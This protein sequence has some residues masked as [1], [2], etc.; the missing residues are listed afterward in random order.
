M[1]TKSL[2]RLL[3][4]AGAIA[5]VAAVSVS[6]YLNPPSAV[7]AHALDQ[8]R[9]Q[10]L[11]QIDSAIKAYYRRHQVLPD[12]LDAVESKNGLSARPNWNDPVTH[13]PYEYD[14]LSKTSYRLCADFSADSESQEN[15]Y[16][17]SFRK[18]HKGHDCFQ[19]EVNTG[20]I[21]IACQVECRRQQTRR[22]RLSLTPSRRPRSVTA[23]LAGSRS[24]SAIFCTCSAST[25]STRAMISSAV[26]NWPK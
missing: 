17:F 13:Q 5:A 6:I 20:A 11:Q 8:E 22:W 19:Q 15:P 16:A 23:I 10:G 7:K 24:R 25:A 14:V 9:L 18:H 3:A 12:G 4:I 26:K 21:P 2:G 1:N